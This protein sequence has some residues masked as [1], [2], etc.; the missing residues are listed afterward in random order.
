M[1]DI[2]KMFANTDFSKH[3]D[4]KHRLRKQLFQS[5]GSSKVTSF[6]FQSLSDDDMGLVNAAQGIWQDDDPDKKN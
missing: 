6:P 4:L 3:T 1:K 2:E 5:A